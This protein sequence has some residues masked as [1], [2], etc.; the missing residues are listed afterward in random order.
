MIDPVWMLDNCRQSILSLTSISAP[1]WRNQGVTCMA[2]GAMTSWNKEFGRLSWIEMSLAYSGLSFSSKTID[3]TSSI[4]TVS[5]PFQEAKRIKSAP[6]K[7]M[8]ELR[9]MVNDLFQALNLSISISEEKSTVGGKVYESLKFGITSKY[10][11]EV[12]KELLTKFSG[13]RVNNIRYVDGVWNYEGAIYV[14]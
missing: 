1:G 3:P 4:V 8:T 5:L 2:S 13:L 7:T 12:W 10:D 11:P 9:H 6:K 14:Q